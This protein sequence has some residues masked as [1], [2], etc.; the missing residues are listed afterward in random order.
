MAAELCRIAARH[1]M[2]YDDCAWISKDGKTF[3][4]I[5]DSDNGEC[6]IYWD[7]DAQQLL[8]PGE[9][10]GTTQVSAPVDDPDAVIERWMSRPHLT[11]D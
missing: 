11:D 10:D 5:I 3:S 4:G 9:D 8:E 2:S 6:I 7:S 1:G